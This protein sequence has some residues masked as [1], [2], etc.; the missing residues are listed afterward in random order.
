MTQPPAP[1][2]GASVLQLVIAIQFNSL[3]N[4]SVIVLKAKRFKRSRR[5]A[6]F[7]VCASTRHLEDFHGFAK[8]LDEKPVNDVRR[9]INHGH[10]LVNLELDG[11]TARRPRTVYE[12]RDDAKNIQYVK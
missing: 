5:L 3:I 7:T 4:R 6:R 10:N 2:T 9:N 8:H 11:R 12:S 1:P